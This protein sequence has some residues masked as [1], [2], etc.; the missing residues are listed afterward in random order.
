MRERVRARR[1]FTL[2]ELLIVVAIIAVLVAVSI[3]IFSAQTEKARRAVDISN[4]RSLMSALAMG[5]VSGD[6]SFQNDNSAVWVY[7]CPTG[8][9]YAANGAAWPVIR[10]KTD[11]ES[12][13]ELK[14]LVSAAGPAEASLPIHCRQPRDTGSVGTDEGWTWYCVFLLPDGTVGASSGPGNYTVFSNPGSFSSFRGGT[15]AK[16]LYTNYEKSA[17]ARALRGE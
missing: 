1:G 16:L 9:T 4:A 8:V 2:G 7:V 10:G 6:I 15:G 5:Y 17:M 3:P 14:K 12:W 11:S 13:A